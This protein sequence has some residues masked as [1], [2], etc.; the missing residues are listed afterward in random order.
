[1]N[2]IGDILIVQDKEEYYMYWKRLSLQQRIICYYMQCA[3]HLV[4]RLYSQQVNKYSQLFIDSLYLLINRMKKTDDH[5]N[6]VFTLFTYL[7]INHSQYAIY[8]NHNEK[9]VPADLNLTL[10]SDIL[11]ALFDKY[12]LTEIANKTQLIQSELFDKSFYQNLVTPGSVEQS[13]SNLYD[14]GLTTEYVT[15]LKN[16][17]VNTRIGS[18]G[19]IEL[20]YQDGLGKMEINVIISHLQQL[21]DYLKMCPN[22]TNRFKMS[23]EY[24]IL[25]LVTGE[26]C[27][28]KT[29]SIEWL[30]ITDALD[31]S[32]GP[33]ETYIDP[34]AIRGAFQSEVFIKTNELLGLSDLIKQIELKLP[35]DPEFINKNNK[36][37]Y[38]PSITY[39]LFGN[40]ASGPINT[41]AAY[42][43]PNFQDI[44]EK[45]GSKQVI[46]QHSPSIAERLN[47]QQWIELFY[48]K[49]EM[50]WFSKYNPEYKLD[51]W[52]WIIHCILHETI[53]HGSGIIINNKP[54]IGYENT[55]EELRAEI[56]T[57]YVSLFHFRELYDYGL[58]EDYK[59]IPEDDLKRR[60]IICMCN[61]ALHRIMKQPNRILTVYEQKNQKV[62]IFGDHAL[63]NV[64]ILYYLF[65]S[66][67]ID[68]SISN[69]VSIEVK[70][71][72]ICMNC[73]KELAVT[74]QRVKSMSDINEAKKLINTYARFVPLTIHSI[75]H[76]NY[77]QVNK[78]LKAIA[79]LKPILIVKKDN[80]KIIDVELHWPNNFH[81]QMKL[82][83]QRTLTT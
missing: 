43:L 13:S 16:T 54:L 24:L 35:F 15:S 67:G 47:K 7:Y 9:H 40:G 78:G 19:K 46:Y 48:S 57:L 36:K 31:Y 66:G 52:I 37:I 45:I 1:M 56:I 2:V 50:S 58:F 65:R 55:I 49:T 62:E 33:I 29:H 80:N 8:E 74:V 82:A 22:I 20:W 69:I 53:G 17:Q 72:H 21:N 5:Y 6:D 73:I 83:S 64:C 63:A 18:N 32:F 3:S 76:N 28:L 38:N 14:R 51:N 70:D 81:E 77:K 39:Q 61:I 4:D 11:T 41:T 27:Y 71:L 44:R 68:M 75:L 25:F 42:C 10:T 79:H 34:L 30:K 12:G 26:Q 60:L 59:H 23:I